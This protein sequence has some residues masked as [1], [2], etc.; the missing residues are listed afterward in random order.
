MKNKGE[1]IVIDPRAED[2]AV[3]A[4]TGLSTRGARLNWINDDMTLQTGF[5]KDN[6]RAWSVID[7]RNTSEVMAQ[8][9]LASGVSN[10]FS[11]FDP[12]LSYFILAGRGD[13]TTE[14][15][16][17]DTSSTKVVE[18]LG[19]Y[20]FTDS[21]LYFTL[22]D[23]KNVDVSNNELARGV[24]VGQKKNLEVFSYYIPSK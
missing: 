22:M 18:K 20:K 15:Y 9:K 17:L 21:T 5:D 13:P 8:G 4:V 6:N 12:T 16:T 24:R 1:M 19:E 14:F 23:K 3:T 7:M 11:Y 2:S 10:A